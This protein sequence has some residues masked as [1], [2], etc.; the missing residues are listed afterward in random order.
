[1]ISKHKYNFKKKKTESVLR[2][3]SVKVIRN[4]EKDKMQTYVSK[5]FKERNR[6]LKG[7]V[8]C[9]LEHIVKMKQR[10]KMEFE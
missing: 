10:S 2:E 7:H 3:V 8:V 4:W 9:M 1:M 6:A 5:I